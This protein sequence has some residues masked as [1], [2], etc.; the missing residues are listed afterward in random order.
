MWLAAFSAALAFAGRLTSSP[1]KVVYIIRHGEKLKPDVPV[2]PQGYQCLSEKGWARAY[3]LK[4]VF[5]A[6]PMAPFRTPEALFSADYGEP[7]DCRDSHGWYRT[8]QTIS[9]LAAPGP[10]GL[11]L[12]IDNSTGFLPN[13]CGQGVSPAVT[14]AI[15]LAITGLE[16]FLPDEGVAERLLEFV[17]AEVDGIKLGWCAPYGVLGDGTCCNSDAAEKI[18]AKLEDVDVILVAWEHVNI[19]WLAKELGAPKTAVIDGKCGQEECWPGDDYDRV[20]AL[21]YDA[22]GRYLRIETDLAQGFTTNGGAWLGPQI[23]CGA[24][25]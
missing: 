11:N 7:F 5:G 14:E 25:A 17:R 4:S 20:Y 1:E 8:Q 22:S 2:P 21:Y 9:A 16:K 13:L 18:K 24:V 10:G 19:Q 3:N 6:R 15:D 12:T 23:G